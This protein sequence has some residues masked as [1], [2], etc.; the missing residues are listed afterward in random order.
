MSLNIFCTLILPYVLNSPVAVYTWVSFNLPKLYCLYINSK[1][2]V[3][4]FFSV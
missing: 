1:I 3:L 2:S 4:S